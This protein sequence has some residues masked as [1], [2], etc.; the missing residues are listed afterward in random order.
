M[1]TMVG[2]SFN[3]V[4]FL[5]VLWLPGFAVDV[6]SVAYRKYSRVI[7]MEKAGSK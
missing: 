5:N 4:T 6:V 3:S 7:T 2:E 1:N